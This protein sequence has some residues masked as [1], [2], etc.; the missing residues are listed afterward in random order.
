MNPEPF[1]VVAIISSRLD[2]TVTEAISSSV[3]LTARM[4]SKEYH[5]ASPRWQG[6][7]GDTQVA[8]GAAESL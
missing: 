8:P 1:H 6:A 2:F 3:F 5:F 7:G 4:T